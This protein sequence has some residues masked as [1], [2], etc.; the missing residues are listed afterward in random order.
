MSK[1]LEAIR[2]DSSNGNWAVDFLKQPESS[3]HIVPDHV[4]SE[5]REFDMIYKNAQN[6][7]E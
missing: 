3:H 5:F 2:H 7:S 1:E 4:H 6:Q